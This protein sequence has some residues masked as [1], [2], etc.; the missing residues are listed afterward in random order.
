MPKK[1]MSFT[2]IELL[3]VIAI[4][5]ILAAML[6]PAL[7]QSRERGHSSQCISNVKQLC[8]ASSLYR[9]DFAGY[10]EINRYYQKFID[11]NY[12]ELKSKVFVCPKD[13]P[14]TTYGNQDDSQLSYGVPWGFPTGQQ[15]Y[16][17]DKI[18]KASIGILFSETH[19]KKSIRGDGWQWPVNL[20]YK[21]AQGGSNDDGS[22]YPHNWRCTLGFVDGHTEPCTRQEIQSRKLLNKYDDM[23]K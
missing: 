4:I 11:G 14:R 12:I 21:K 1:S 15:F 17:F 2:L 6:L 18:R 19:S 9:N 8:A 10:F 13:R 23:T 7:N 16:Q 22:D 20:A 3:V 5:A